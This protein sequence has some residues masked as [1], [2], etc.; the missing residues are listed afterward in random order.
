MRTLRKANV[1]QLLAD[2]DQVKKNLETIQAQMSSTVQTALVDGQITDPAILSQVEGC[3]TQA[4]SILT[5]YTAGFVRFCR[6]V[7]KSQSADKPDEAF[8]ENVRTIRADAE[9]IL[10]DFEWTLNHLRQQLVL[11]NMALGDLSSVTPPTTPEAQ[12]PPSDKGK[13]IPAPPTIMTA[14]EAAGSA[15]TGKLPEGPLGGQ[16]E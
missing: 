6:S 14:Q 13:A 7:A 10:Q 1:I 5:D 3:L 9:G 12:E 4:K 11:H 15:G 2:Y 16:E 8:L